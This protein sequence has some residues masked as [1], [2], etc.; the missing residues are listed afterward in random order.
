MY[1]TKLERKD[2]Y[3]RGLQ[4][5]KSALAEELRAAKRFAA[6]REQHVADLKEQVAASEAA[7]FALNSKANDEVSKEKE[8]TMTDDISAPSSRILTAENASLRYNFIHITCGYLWVTQ[9][10]NESDIAG[11]S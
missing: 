5:E 6:E 4:D 8:D 1:R 9:Y 7:A 3:A 2:E 10:V 11:I